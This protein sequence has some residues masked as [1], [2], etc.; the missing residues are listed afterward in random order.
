LALFRF[1]LLYF[2]L[3]ELLWGRRLFAVLECE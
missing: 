2:G 3:L 1:V